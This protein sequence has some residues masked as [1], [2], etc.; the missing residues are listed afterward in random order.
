MCADATDVHT[1]LSTPRRARG[2]AARGPRIGSVTL[3]DQRVRYA[4]GGRADAERTLLLFNGFGAHVETVAAFMSHFERTRVVA[5]DAPGVG[6][7]PAPP[8]PYRPH[9][10]A[11]LAARLLDHLKID[12]AHVLGV[13]WGGA[14]A[15]EF[16]I[17]HAQRCRTLTLAAT[18]AGFVTLPGRPLGLL[19]MLN[20]CLGLAR[21]LRPGVHL[22]ALHPGP[23]GFLYQLLAIW[24]WTSW[25]RLHHVQAPTLVL[26]G[27]DDPFVAPINGH[28]VASCL[29]NAV[30]ES[31]DCGHLFVFERAGET[32]RRVERFVEQ[33]PA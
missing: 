17:Q 25:Q 6:E 7:S 13:S 31:V 33:Q 15:Q 2:G 18:S 8:L 10:V 16:A 19:K 32:A 28:I 20:P 26:M 23:L 21:A 29:R 14:A 11:E 4:L 5:F 9:H 30:L 1:S 22:Q 12:R 3:G 27:E 24:G